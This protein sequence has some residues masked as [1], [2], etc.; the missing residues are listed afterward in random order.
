MDK[1]HDICYWCGGRIN[2]DGECV[3]FCDPHNH[4]HE[5]FGPDLSHL[6]ITIKENNVG[7]KNDPYGR[8]TTT[9]NVADGCGCSV[10]HRLSIIQCAL[11]GT[12][13][14]LDGE[15]IGVTA[16]FNDIEK[17]RA[18]YDVFEKLVGYSIDDVQLWYHSNYE[19]DPIGPILRY[20]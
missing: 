12:W 6:D 17:T 1:E 4:N 14:K 7:P 13:I 2:A 10:R 20:E 5:Y 8:T 11:V 19:S 3:D 18:V 16:D 9:V 15:E